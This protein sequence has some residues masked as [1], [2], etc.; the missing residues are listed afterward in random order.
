[1]NIVEAK[2]ET[3]ALFYENLKNEAPA[4]FGY[5]PPVR[6]EGV[7]TET[8]PDPSKPYCKVHME[9]IVSNQRAFIHCP[10]N[11]GGRLFASEG[12]AEFIIF[13]PMRLSNAFTKGEQLW[14]NLRKA[15]RKPRSNSVLWFENAVIHKRPPMDERFKIILTVEFFYTEDE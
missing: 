10:D 13:L 12:I 14:A 9:E 3:Y 6:W 15:F 5:V 4:I 11:T 8:A 2:T 7:E 1:M